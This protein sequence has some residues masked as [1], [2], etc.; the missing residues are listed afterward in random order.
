[1]LLTANYLESKQD[2]LYEKYNAFSKNHSFIGR[3]GSL[4]VALIDLTLD[5]LKTPLVIIECIA[6]AI[7]HLIA[8]FFTI[9]DPWEEN[10]LCDSNGDKRYTILPSVKQAVLNVEQALNLVAAIPVTLLFLPIKIFYQTLVCFY[11]PKHVTSIIYFNS[12][13]V[14]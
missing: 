6:K 2:S 10:E 4:P 8:K 14:V 7:L 3:L 5:S 12:F 13:L 9:P 1:M 11:D